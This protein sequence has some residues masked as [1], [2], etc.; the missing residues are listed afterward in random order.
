MV[1][2]LA[3][4]IYLWRHENVETEMCT[5]TALDKWHGVWKGG[6]SGEV[7][8][9]DIC[10]GQNLFSFCSNILYFVAHLEY[11]WEEVNYYLLYDTWNGIVFKRNQ[12]L[13]FITKNGLN[14]L[15]QIT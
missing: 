1:L 10:Y 5:H 3:L 4:V 14:G 7:G 8:E 6:V 2:I 9:M 12:F 11:M 13:I 15:S